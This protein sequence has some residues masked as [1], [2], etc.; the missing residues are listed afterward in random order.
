MAR[1]LDKKSKYEY[2][3]L[4]GLT[5]TYD[6][7]ILKKAYLA[8]IREWHPDL[9]E[10]NG[11]SADEASEMTKK[12]NNAFVELSGIL[13]D[14]SST[15]TCETSPDSYSTASASS[16]AYANASAG[17]TTTG[18]TRNAHSTSSASSRAK[19]N[20]ASNANA[21]SNAT[22]EPDWG[23][24]TVEDTGAADAHARGAV[25]RNM[26]AA[27]RYTSIVT[28]TGYIKWFVDGIGPHIVFAVACAALLAL[29][30]L[31]MSGIYG[32]WGVVMMVRLTP[33]AIIWDIVTGKG[34]ELVG[35]AADIWAVNK[36][37]KSTK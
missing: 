23:Y 4:L 8:Q 28:D 22:A 32:I 11:H 30:G 14:S 26:A 35:S 12:I 3:H 33:I 37:V 21:S 20:A 17:R 10:R 6:K 19:A 16:T 27:M 1:P 29:V 5:G 31:L 9:A 24:D 13:A 18:S 2:E 36:A 7:K 34:A 15:A 25:P